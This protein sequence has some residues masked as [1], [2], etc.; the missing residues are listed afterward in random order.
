MSILNPTLEG[1][2]TPWVVNPAPRPN[3][4]AKIQKLLQLRA[5]IRQKSLKSFIISHILCIFILDN[6]LLKQMNDSCILDKNDEKLV[7][8]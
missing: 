2:R 4:I 6:E 5:N 3:A 7:P 8:E 1:N